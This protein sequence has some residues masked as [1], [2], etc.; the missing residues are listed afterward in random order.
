ME[1]NSEFPIQVKN[2]SSLVKSKKEPEALLMTLLDTH[3]LKL[4]LVAYKTP[5]STTMS[6]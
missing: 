5:L 6:K 4:R 2:Q 3:Y 1:R